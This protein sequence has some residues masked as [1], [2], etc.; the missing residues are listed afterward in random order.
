M[1]PSKRA[2]TD[3]PASPEVI[4]CYGDSNTYGQ[5]DVSDDRL[6]YN[7]R[8]TTALQKKLGDGYVVIPEGLNGRTT[9][10][11]DP[12]E[13]SDFCGVDGSG[14][15]GRRYLLPCLYSHRP[16]TCV[17]LALGC[18]QFLMRTRTQDRRSSRS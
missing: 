8:W 17:V 3:P 12:L 9:T 10:L 5:S 11:D 18:V 13:S 6:P 14:M 16:I 7:D 15:N 1:P 4:L 2:R